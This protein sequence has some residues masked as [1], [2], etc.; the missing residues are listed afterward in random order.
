VVRVRRDPLGPQFGWLWAAF[1]V[2]TFGTW[3]AFDAFSMVAILALHARPL[4]VSLLAAAG[5]AVGAVVAVPLGPWVEQRRK[6]RVMIMMDAV[7]FVALASIPIAYAA[8]RLTFAHLVGVAVVVGAA[9]ICFRAASGSCLKSLVAPEQLLTA[10]ARFE[11]TTWTATMIGPPVGGALISSFG[12]VTTVI[13]D[14]VS[15]LLSALG[16][17]AIPGREPSP[18]AMVPGRRRRGEILE[19]WRY[20]LGHQ[21]LRRLLAN[22]VLFNGLLMATAPLIAVL[23]LSRLGIAPW[24]YGLAFAAPCVGGLVGSRLARRFATRLGTHK[25]LRQAGTL[26]AGWPAAL[27][28]IPS[29]TA[30]VVYVAVVQLG[31]ITTCAVFNPVFATYRLEQTPVDRVARTLAAWTV[32]TKTSVAALTALWGVLANF[33]GLRVAIGV[34]GAILLATPLLLPRRGHLEAGA[35]HATVHPHPVAA[36]HE[37]LD[38]TSRSGG[39]D[40]ELPLQILAAN[41]PGTSQQHESATAT[42]SR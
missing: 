29:G 1:A 9:D 36:A 15:Y 21:P 31:L 13:A 17:R 37:R 11:S 26:R 42:N 38:V 39:R 28:F 23:M 14:A 8:G 10:N 41:R 5:L 25:V 24:Q 12:P 35:H 3:L 7:R 27:A 2:S 40:V 19:G 30:G 32:S 18:S 20:I 6:R 16:I 33:V 34:A 4:E 22:A